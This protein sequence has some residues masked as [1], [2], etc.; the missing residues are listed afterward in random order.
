M[1]KKTELVLLKSTPSTLI[2][3]GIHE[4]IIV[5]EKGR[6]ELAVIIDDDTRV[7][8]VREAWGTIASQREAIRRV[9]GDDFSKI[10]PL[11]RL[12]KV[13]MHEQ[14]Y[15][16]A[17]IAM[18]SN[19]E[20]LINLCR[21]A[22]ELDAGQIDMARLSMFFA[23]THLRAMRMKESAIAE[24]TWS[25]LS[26]IRARRA[27]WTLDGG[28]VSKQ[29]VVDAVKQYERELTSEA[30]VIKKLPPTE[31]RR[32]DQLKHDPGWELADKLLRKKPNSGGLERLKQA[33][34]RV[35]SAEKVEKSG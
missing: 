17:E 7:E 21:A 2:A 8:E 20:C 26:E 15:S 16:Y 22:I 33:H 5:N 4:R 12:G 27:P 3:P 14:G 6:L 29:R 24:H 23:Q 25:G 31:Y 19:Y 34:V 32:A 9:Q 30:V 35:L 28:P 1:A 10:L 11:I 13:A 18:D